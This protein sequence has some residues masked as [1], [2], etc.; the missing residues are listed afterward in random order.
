[1][2]TYASWHYSILLLVHVTLT[3]SPVCA[4]VPPTTPT[5]P[6]TPPTP[7]PTT[8]P[9]TTVMI[10]TRPLPPNGCFYEGRIY[11][12]SKFSVLTKIYDAQ[13]IWAST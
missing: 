8:H 9:P 13:H 1:M 7:P 6:P 10:T 12:D 3:N 4:T 5:T 2:A 11:A